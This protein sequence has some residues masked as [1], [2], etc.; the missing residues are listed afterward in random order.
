MLSQP[1]TRLPP[2]RYF[3]RLDTATT[4][5]QHQARL[6]AEVHIVYWSAARPASSA[7][8]VIVHRSPAVKYEA[9]RVVLGPDGAEQ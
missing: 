9:C 2:G 3:D 4:Y 8:R 1:A 5:A 6:A 7:Y